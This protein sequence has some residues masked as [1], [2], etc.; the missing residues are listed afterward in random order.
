MGPTTTVEVAQPVPGAAPA[1]LASGLDKYSACMRS[2]GV[3]GFPDPVVSGSSIHLV[4]TPVISA[5]P[6]YAKARVACQGLLPARPGSQSFSTQ[7]QDD[8]LKAAACMRDHGI[9]GFPD[10]DFS[11]GR[12]SF[13]LP[14]GM[15][16]NSAQFEAAREICEKLIPQG[17]PYSSGDN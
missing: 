1:K 11:G 10:P 5:S 7:Q 13:P 3:A 2:H 17:L 12:V 14:A 6:A 15:N 4:L 9:T 16:A 8:Y